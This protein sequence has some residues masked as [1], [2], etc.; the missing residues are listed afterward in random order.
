MT[1]LRFIL[2]LVF[3]GARPFFR[4]SLRKLVPPFTASSLLEI[5]WSEFLVVTK[6]VNNHAIDLKKMMRSGKLVS[7]YSNLIPFETV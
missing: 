3:L 2:A 4:K 1:P 6:T 5:F 7:S